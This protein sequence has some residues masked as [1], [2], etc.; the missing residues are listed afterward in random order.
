MDDQANDQGLSGVFVGFG[1]LL[2]VLGALIFVG[3]AIGFDL[4]S[5]GWPF[6]VIISGLA[7]CGAGL[8][9]GGPPASV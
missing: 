2:I 9:A 8:A 5:L 1:A 4:G 6:F 7:F 3:K